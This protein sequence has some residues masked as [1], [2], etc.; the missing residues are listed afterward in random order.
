[1]SEFSRIIKWSPGYDY[2]GDPE[3]RQYGAH[4]LEMR[5]LLRGPKATVQF[6]V[7]TGWLPTWQHFGGP[8]SHEVLP[9]DVGYHA[10]APQYEGQTSMECKERSQG[11][12]Y[13]D[14]SS[15]AAD[16]VFQL[17]VTKGDEAVW[18]ELQ[19]RYDHWFCKVT[20]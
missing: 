10:D 11:H 4:G 1:M 18:E 20:P 19:R 13:Y 17:L 2:R 7:M 9:A 15:L 16:D 8:P 14:G 3:K 6:V 12:C 5:F